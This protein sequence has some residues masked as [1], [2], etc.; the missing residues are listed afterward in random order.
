MKDN[1]SLSEIIKHRIEKLEKINSSSVDTFKY[2]FKSSVYAA[3][4]FT[5]EE[6]FLKKDISICGRIISLRKMGKACFAHIQDNSGKIQLYIKTNHLP[7]NIYDVIVRNLDIGDIIGVKGKIFHT[8]TNELT[9]DVS[10]LDILAKNIRPLPN[11]KEKDGQTYFAF[12][13]KELR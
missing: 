4:I 7:E 1:R 8:K 9:I 11:I 12:R 3:E 2:S 5:N 10:D 13:N 6:S